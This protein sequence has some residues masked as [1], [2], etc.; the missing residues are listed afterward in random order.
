MRRDTTNN[1]VNGEL[2]DDTRIKIVDNNTEEDDSI[3][4]MFKM[5]VLRTPELHSDNIGDG[6][7]DYNNPPSI[8]QPVQTVLEKQLN[9]V[10]L[11]Y[12]R[13]RRMELQL[14]LTPGARSMRNI[15]KD[16]LEDIEEHDVDR[17]EEIGF[18]RRTFWKSCCGQIIDRRATQFFAQIF[19]GVGIMVFCMVKICL[20]VPLYGCD[21]EDTTV[22]FSLLSALVGFYIPSPSMH[23]Q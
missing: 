1:S 13:N 8:D 23:K 12:E 4:P 3:P 18:R 16:G 14:G 15:L 10:R 22:Y 6:Y 19:I 7:M 17:R 20:A 5:R 9:I 21:G 11:K 2:L